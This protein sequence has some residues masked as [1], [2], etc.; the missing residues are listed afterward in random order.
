[1]LQVEATLSNGS[2]AVAPLR[3]RTLPD[4]V[5]DAIVEAIASGVLQPGERIVE[6]KLAEALGIS[7]L[8]V[9]E[10]LRVLSGQGLVTVAPHRGCRVADFNLEKVDQQ[11]D[12]RV[13]LE[14]VAARAASAAYRADP[15]ALRPL[16]KALA[17]LAETVKRGDRL[18]VARSDL[19]FHHV[20]WGIAGN[21]LLMR[22]WEAISRHIIVIFGLETKTE[23]DVEGIYR[24]HERL[25]SMIE[26]GD[27]Q[28]L[29]DEIERHIR[30]LGYMCT[31]RE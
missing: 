2:A 12:V 28:E 21:D 14:K 24:Q 8:P 26:A 9:R 18:A 3:L 19:Q 6:Q 23:L 4:Q 25:L 1:M 15:D 31:K 7:R 10:G 5:A 29:D 22:M 13:G 16:H 11:K 27:D 30:Q 17:Q 20:L